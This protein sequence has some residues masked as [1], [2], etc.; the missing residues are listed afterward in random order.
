SLGRW[1]S[2]VALVLVTIMVGLYHRF[3]SRLLDK[4]EGWVA[5]VQA[6]A[7]SLLLLGLTWGMAVV[8]GMGIVL[9]LIH[10]LPL[11]S[12][13]TKRQITIVGVALTSL[14]IYGLLIFSNHP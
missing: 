3:Q 9:I 13:G 6:T 5:F 4:G 10:H 11:K 7:L 12:A 2:T 14:V 8:V 1:D